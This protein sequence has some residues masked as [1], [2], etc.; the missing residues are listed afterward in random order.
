MYYVLNL[1]SL[2]LKPAQDPADC[3]CVYVLLG[4]SMGLWWKDNQQRKLKKL[5]L[6]CHFVHHKS[7]CEPDT[8]W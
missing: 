7:S 1:N 5:L 8:L 2:T 6:L 3:K 4:H